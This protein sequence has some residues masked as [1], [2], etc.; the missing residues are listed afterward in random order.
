MESF[1]QD[2]RL[3][4]RLLLKQ[5]AFSLLAI[6]TLALGIGLSTALFSVL[7]AAFIRPLP[8]ANPEQLVDIDVGEPRRDR[9]SYLAPSLADI[10]D[11]QAHGGIFTHIG[12]SRNA[13]TQPLILDGDQP[14]RVLAMRV[15][16]DFFP[17]YGVV[18]LLGRSFTDDE[19]ATGN[20]A[21]V[22][23]GYDFWTTRFAAD[24]AVVGTHIRLNAEPV[25]II[26]VLPSWFYAKTK[27]WRPFDM[28]AD[29]LV[30][31]RGSG[32]GVDGRLRAGLSLADAQ[33]A[34]NALL[35]RAATE[36]GGPTAT[37]RLTSLYESATRGNVKTAR[38]ITYGV[39]LVLLLA[40]VNVAGLLLARGAAR[41]PELAV[42]ASLGAGRARLVRQLLT[43]SLV[44]AT[45]G[46]ILGVGLAWLS[47]DLL[48][49]NIPMSLPANAP[50]T[51]NAKALAFA[52]AAALGTSLLFGL[53]PAWRV[54][55]VKAGDALARAGRGKGAALSHRTGQALIGLEVALALV[56]LAGSGIMLRSFAKLS[57]VDLGF[58]PDAVLAME[59][60]PATPGRAAQADYYPALL[61]R[62]A[63][64]PG[65]GAAGAVDYPPLIGGSTVTFADARELSTQIGVRQFLGN[66]FEAIGATIKDGR[67][68]TDADRNRAVPLAVINESARKALFGDGRAVGEQFRI[69][70][71]TPY[72]V[73]AVISDLRHS[74]PLYK[75][76]PEFWRLF[77]PADEHGRGMVVMV[78][79]RGANTIDPVTLR[80]IAHG[81]G[82]TVVIEK[83]ARGTSWLSE[84][85]VTPRRR[86]VLLGLLG[87]LGMLLALVGVF[88]M[89]AYA[90]A[91]RTQEIGVRMAFGATPGAVVRA[92][93]R[94]SAWPVGCGVAV[95][96]LGSWWATQIIA[97]FLFETEPRDLITFAWV[98]S[99][100]AAA[101]IIAAWIPARRAARVDPIVALRAE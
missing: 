63:A 66:Y 84:R 69:A 61:E 25:T 14:Q 72:E 80:Q 62:L 6:T 35:T 68:P 7:D 30:R 94:D 1:R 20:P 18:P 23:L 3:A 56:L 21:V 86:T 77:D 54:S 57:Q 36:R 90:V 64:H 82:R 16:K 52:V 27:I 15:S 42:R 4:I 76:E 33:V 37:V 46:A 71:R 81:L 24:S 11:W 60:S 39:T 65:V 79:P 75:P 5:P 19:F 98:A 34:L 73:A 31:Q 97:S 67:I 47:L 101:A 87:G 91:R 74:G 13:F 28:T 89:T 95:G 78:R 83:V 51:I 40:C 41:R 10:R 43:E 38:I 70:R 12:F 59:V 45:G 50:V 26:G 32:A 92:A 49:A 93:L 17:M 2:V 58:A 85:V 48:V 9:I 100:L 44:L 29:S 53:V 8:Y 22:I 55:R 99:L 96:L 88:G